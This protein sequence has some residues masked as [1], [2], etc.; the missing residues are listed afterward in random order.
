MDKTF[1]NTGLDRSIPHIGVLM[2]KTDTREYPRHGLPAGYVFSCYRPGFEKQWASLQYEVGQCDS[3]E[4][5]EGIFKGTFMAPPGLRPPPSQAKGAL[6]E[7]EALAKKTIFVFDE[8]HNL[9]GTGAI[10]DGNH[11]GM[12]L[13]RLHWIAVAPKHQGQ[14]IAKAIVSRLLDLYNGLG[15]DGYIYLTSQTWSWRAL[16][17]YM[18]FGFRPYMGE[19]PVNWRCEDFE[20]E[21][22]EAWGMIGGKIGIDL[23]TG[24]M[25]GDA[26]PYVST[27]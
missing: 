13:Q 3:I 10:W 8:E 18:G 26:L 4:E 15:Y 7:E 23:R 6:P 14:G 2:E 12:T 19:R 9:V 24:G 16:K 27:E 20:E 21:T 1:L 5:A 25:G 22:A 11:F 17:L